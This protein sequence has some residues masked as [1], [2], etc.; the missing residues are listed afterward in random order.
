VLARERNEVSNATRFWPA[1]D[2]PQLKLFGE[3]SYAAGRGFTMN[4]FAQM[5]YEH[6]MPINVLMSDMAGNDEGGG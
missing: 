4:G 6:R 1:A 5:A 2:L 3:R